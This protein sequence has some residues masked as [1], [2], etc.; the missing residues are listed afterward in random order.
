M[1][2]A[3]CSSVVEN[4][5]TH[6]CNQLIYLRYSGDYINGSKNGYGIIKFLNGQEYEGEFKNGTYEITQR[7][8]DIYIDQVFKLAKDRAGFDKSPSSTRYIIDRLNPSLINKTKVDD[9][10]I[11]QIYGQVKD[12][13]EAYISTVAELAGFLSTDAYYTTFK[14]MADKS[15]IETAEKNEIFLA[16]G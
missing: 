1:Q 16:S 3:L 6:Q 14:N 12:P 15:I 10:I 5:P 4:F 2:F 13:R 7:Q 8:A 11:Q 9:K